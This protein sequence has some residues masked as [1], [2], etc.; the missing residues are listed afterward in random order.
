MV[1]P[2]RGGDVLWRVR[3]RQHERR[4]APDRTAALL[5][6][7]PLEI[8]LLVPDPLLLLI[9]P[10]VGLRE[11]LLELLDLLHELLPLLPGVREAL[12]V[13]LEVQLQM[14]HGAWLLLCS[15]LPVQCNENGGVRVEDSRT[16]R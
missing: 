14:P 15:E 16:L 12:A 13:E 1:R 7:L 6:R 2:P 8:D 9:E 3:L 4:G 11:G 10:P 5:R